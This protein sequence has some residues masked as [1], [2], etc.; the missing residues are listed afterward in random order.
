METFIEKIIEENKKKFTNNE[1][2]IMKKNM[3]LIKKIYLLGLFS[4]RETYIK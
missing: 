2:I 3:Q 4:G 1:I